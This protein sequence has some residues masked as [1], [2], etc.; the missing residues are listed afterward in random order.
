MRGDPILLLPPRDG[1]PVIVAAARIPSVRTD[2]RMVRYASGWGETPDEAL[3]ACQ[4]E[5]AERTAAQFVGDEHFVRC[6]SAML[7]GKA[8]LPPDIMLFSDLQYDGHE[9]KR[10]G[11][12]VPDDFPCR[13]RTDT[14]IDWI[15]ATAGLSSGEAWLPAGLC[16]LGYHRDRAAGL[17]PADTNGLATGTSAEDACVRAFVELVE[18]DAAAVW[19]YGQLPR[20]SVDVA[21]IDDALVA[22]YDAWTAAVG[23]PLRIID[24]THDF[25]I[26]VV[27][28]VAHDLNGRCIA[29]G[30]GAGT[31]MPEAARHAI[32]ELVQFE[33]NIAL[34]ERRIGSSGESGT[35]PEA[36]SLLR[37]WREARVDRCPHLNMLPTRRAKAYLS[38]L[39]LGVCHAL[40]ARRGLQFAALDMTR[41]ESEV[42]VA[43]VFVPGLRPLWPRFAPGRLFNVPVEMGWLQRPLAESELN[44]TPI[45][46]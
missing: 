25:S 45:M 12:G 11:E 6:T 38:S 35:T 36:L 46:F 13:W 19:W 42:W 15:A 4:R 37:W 21:E 34:I 44:S 32:G 29:I 8:V 26:P 7:G 5:V 20:P 14:V 9:E 18:R 24:L 43:R 22:R 39:D 23:R 3:L 30:L 33:N 41:S 17:V 31:T 10:R 16:F 40:C 2:D 28:A 1:C 27:A